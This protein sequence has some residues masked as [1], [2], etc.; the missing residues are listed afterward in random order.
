MPARFDAP[1]EVIRQRALTNLKGRI[2][3]ESNLYTRRNS[4][5]SFSS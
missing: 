1:F 5:N 3:A 2:Y 4:R